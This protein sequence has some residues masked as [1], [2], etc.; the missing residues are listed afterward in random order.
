MLQQIRIGNFS[1]KTVRHVDRALHASCG[2]CENQLGPE[3]LEQDAA[4]ER[5]GGRHRQDELV[6]E[7]C[8]DEG[9]TDARVAAGGLDEH[10][11]AGRD[12]A[13]RLGVLDHGIA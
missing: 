11:L 3:A 7:R 6:P 13:D 12:L 8:G 5:H 2:V 1:A 4:L 10:G 9:Q